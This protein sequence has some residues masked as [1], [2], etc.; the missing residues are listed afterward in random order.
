MV[1]TDIIGTAGVSLL[2][3]AFFLNLFFKMPKEGFTYLLL[4]VVGAGLAF[5]ASVLLMYWPFINLEAAWTVVS[6]FALIQT[7]VKK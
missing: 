5:V 2:L 7:L 4:N 3:L 6:L 1:L